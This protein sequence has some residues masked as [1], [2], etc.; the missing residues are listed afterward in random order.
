MKTRRFGFSSLA[1]FICGLMILQPAFAQQSPDTFG[2]KLRIENGDNGSTTVKLPATEPIVVVVTDSKDQPVQGALVVFSSPD[3]GAGGTFDN[4]SRTI[5]VTTDRNGRA[6]A[7]GYKANS[8]AGT[9]Q[10]EVRSQLLNE[11]ANAQITHTNVGGGKK[12]T[13]LIAILAIAGAGA[14][15]ALIKASG[16]GGP[17]PI[18]EPQVTIPTISFG[19][20]TV[21]GPQ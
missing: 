12:N 4:E 1:I 2:L 10:I 18:K 5:T 6:T 19:S 17:D 13:K 20:S 8:T 14:A 3:H 21:G 7:S 16:G 11:T 9:Y 15:G